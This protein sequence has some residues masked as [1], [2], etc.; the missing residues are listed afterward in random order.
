MA[1]AKFLWGNSSS[2]DSVDVVA[3]QLILEK[4]T[5]Q[6]HIDTPDGRVAVRDTM[7]D[8]DLELSDN[9]LL[10]SKK[11]GEETLVTQI[12]FPA[13]D[14]IT[15]SSHLSIFPATLDGTSYNYNLFNTGVV[16]SDF[17]DD[18]TWNYSTYT[19]TTGG[20][21]PGA[22]D[23]TRVKMI[24]NNVAEG[25]LS[26]NVFYNDEE[27]TNIFPAMARTIYIDL[28]SGGTYRYNSETTQYELIAGSKQ[29]WGTF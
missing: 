11:D 20:G 26:D 8:C 1:Q 28:L 5:G 3:G 9:K 16:N 18:K 2:V 23:L 14:K 27:L 12:P 15:G 21:S 24:P 19:L 29:T 7:H 22:Q 6:I 25:Y 13:K 4:D 10:W 17:E